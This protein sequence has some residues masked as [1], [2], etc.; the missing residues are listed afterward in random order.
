MTE[1][2]RPLCDCPEPCGCHAQG[3]AAG[4]GKAY[5]EFMASL[6]GPPHARECA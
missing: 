3:Y 5:I 2:G 4:K 6:D 1:T